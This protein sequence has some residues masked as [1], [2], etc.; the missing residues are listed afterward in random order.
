MQYGDIQPSFF[1]NGIDGMGMDIC[2]D[3]TAAVLVAGGGGVKRT[4][5]K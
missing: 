2:Q 1:N 3:A 4:V 5:K